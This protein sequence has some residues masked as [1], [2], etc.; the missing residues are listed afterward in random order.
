MKNDGHEAGEGSSTKFILPDAN[1]LL[2]YKRIDDSAWRDVLGDSFV[3]EISV[4]TVRELDRHRAS[5][6]ARLRKRA[7]KLTNW[8]LR[9]QEGGEVLPAGLEMRFIVNS[10]V[11]LLDS[12]RF[13]RHDPDDVLV[14]SAIQYR[15]AHPDRDLHLVSEDAGVVLKARGNGVS[16]LKP[17]AELRLP[18]ELTEEEEEN[19]RL[20]QEVDKLTLG[21]PSLVLRGK[22]TLVSLSVTEFTEEVE[23]FIERRVAQERQKQTRPHFS[24]LGAFDAGPEA[25][26]RYFDELEAHCRESHPALRRLYR[27]AALPLEL[28]N[29]GR[30]PARDIDLRLSVPDGVSLESELPELPRAPEKPNS[31]LTRLLGAPSPLLSGFHIPNIVDPEWR[32]RGGQE[33]TISLRKLKHGHLH[34]LPRLFLRFDADVFNFQVAWSCSVENAP[35][36]F[37]GEIPVVADEAREPEDL[38]DLIRDEEEDGEG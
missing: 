31:G 21:Q 16:A 10:P 38:T 9:I 30:G 8:F 4:S 22:S 14:A 7:Q 37:G 13:D 35:E 28:V 17:P 3:V 1:V 5:K 26:S 18:A 11:E 36:P 34:R 27:T 2:E 20:R 25:W 32:A 24:A 29:D 23:S 33:A 6:R 12:G 15:E 19:R